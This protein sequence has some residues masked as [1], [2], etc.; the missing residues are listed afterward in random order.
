VPRPL[1]SPEHPL[2]SV[3]LKKY[4]QEQMD[5]G[6]S[7][8]EVKNQIL[9]HGF[10]PKLVRSI[11]GSEAGGR[12]AVVRKSGVRNMAIGGG[13]CLVGL[14]LTFFSFQLAVAADWD[15]FYI[16]SG[17]IVYGTLQFL[18]GLMQTVFGST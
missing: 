2:A 15:K 7:S 14:V 9:P 10:D 1:F 17:A 16:L 4:V 8:Y 5:K 12:R 6:Y 11:V 13:V 3:L 18:Y